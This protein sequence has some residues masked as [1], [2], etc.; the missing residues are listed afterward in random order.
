MLNARAIYRLLI[1]DEQ[2]TLPVEAPPVRAPV[3][4]DDLDPTAEIKRY[5]AEPFNVPG[6]YPTDLYR[7][8]NNQL[9]G[10]SQKKIANNT[11]LINY[12]VNNAGEKIA[13][14]LHQTDV[15]TAFRD[16]KI[17]IDAGGWHPQGSHADHGWRMP[18]GNTTLDR[19]SGNL[20]SGWRIFK[21]K[22]TWYWYNVDSRAGTRH[23]DDR[24]LPYT[25]GD[26]ILPDGSLKMQAHPVYPKRRK[27]R[28]M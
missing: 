7:R 4:P 12:G 27:R 14:R 18:A 6:S 24:M 5:A 3:N 17:V 23:E 28:A 10:R 25:D 19:I 20:D 8:L 11:Y 21:F 16:G 9:G 1:D 15:V 2:P 22:A 26:T 13:V